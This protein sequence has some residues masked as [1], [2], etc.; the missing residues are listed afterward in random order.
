M[1]IVARVSFQ[2][3]KT[4]YCDFERARNFLGIIKR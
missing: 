2:V 3:S 1:Y 4:W